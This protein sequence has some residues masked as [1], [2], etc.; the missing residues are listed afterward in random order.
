MNLSAT[1]NLTNSDPVQLFNVVGNA[2]SFTATAA[3]FAEIAITPR[4]D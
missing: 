4:I 3:Q 2:A 1:F